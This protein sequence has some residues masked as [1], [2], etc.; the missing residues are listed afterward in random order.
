MSTHTQPG[1]SFARTFWSW[2]LTGLVL[3]TAVSFVVS[4]VA[5]GPAGVLSAYATTGAYLLGTLMRRRPNR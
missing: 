3:V 4:W 1:R 2:L 5:D